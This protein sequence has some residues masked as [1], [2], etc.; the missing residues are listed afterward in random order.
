MK[1][2]GGVDEREAKG[3]RKERVQGGRRWERE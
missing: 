1:E 3:R 2:G